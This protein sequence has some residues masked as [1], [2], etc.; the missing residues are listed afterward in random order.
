M[1]GHGRQMDDK[2]T[3]SLLDMIYQSRINMYKHRS[4][5]GS[6]PDRAGK[7]Q[8]PT[9]RGHG[10]FKNGVRLRHGRTGQLGLLRR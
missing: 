8:P 2:H 10:G 6:V 1:A 9:Y 3:T 7:A 5:F 4:H